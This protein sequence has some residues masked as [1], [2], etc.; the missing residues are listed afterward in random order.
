[1]PA[2]TDLVTWNP[3]VGDTGDDRY[4]VPENDEVVFTTASREDAFSDPPTLDEVNAAHGLWQIM[5]EIRRRCPTTNDLFQSSSTQP[6]FTFPDVGVQ[7][8]YNTGTFSLTNLRN[9][10][11]RIRQSELITDVAASYTWTET[12]SAGCPIL[13][14]HI[15][16]MR[17]ALATDCFTLYAYKPDSFPGGAQTYGLQQNLNDA[18]L[19]EL[20]LGKIV[21][22]P[23]PNNVFGHGGAWGVKNSSLTWGRAR[24]Y[25]NFI[26]SSGL[27][28]IGVAK[29]VLPIYVQG[30]GGTIQLYQSSYLGTIGTEDWGSFGTSVA[31]WTP[32]TESPRL[33]TLPTPPVAGDQLSFVLAH[34][35]EVTFSK[36][37]RWG[38]IGSDYTYYRNILLRLY[39]A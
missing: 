28:T 8:R 6:T 29:F 21:W 1:M 11:V 23:D 20:Y 10:I 22:P 26:I 15:K 33:I 14:A 16:E 27:P 24:Q 30:A 5:A 2:G 17:K 34:D 32:A 31:S 39:T 37:S 38:I 25:R 4:T 3:R 7:L 36:V 18:D 13:K 12:I 9:Q 35:S 19:S